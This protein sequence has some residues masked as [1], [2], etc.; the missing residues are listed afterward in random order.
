MLGMV[1]ADSDIIQPLLGQTLAHIINV[2]TQLTGLE[3][4]TF[5]SLICFSRLRFFKHHCSF[6]APYHTDAIVIGVDDIPGIY[7]RPYT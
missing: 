4:C 3:P 5:V 7:Q 6:L 2:Q 1:G